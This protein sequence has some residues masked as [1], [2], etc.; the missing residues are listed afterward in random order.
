M[1]VLIYMF[2]GLVIFL[3]FLYMAYK[4]IGFI[5]RKIFSKYKFSNTYIKFISF[6]II[7]IP[8]I[9]IQFLISDYMNLLY[10]TGNIETKEDGTLKGNANTGNEEKKDTKNE[11]NTHDIDIN[12][13]VMLAGII[14]DEDI[15]ITED[16]IDNTQ[17]VISEFNFEK[18]IYISENSRDIFLNIL[19]DATGLTYSINEQG[20]LNEVSNEKQNN[21][22]EKINKMI[23]S[24]FTTIIDVNEVYKATINN[25]V[26]DFIVEETMYVKNSKYNDNIRISIIN[27]N[28]LYNNEE[29][30][31]KDIAEEILLKILEG[32]ETI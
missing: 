9:I 1:E 17:K 4:F 2:I 16:N 32:I 28:M 30:S 6:I 7:V 15:L 31:K 27:P 21:L 18:G 24:N 11:V 8:Y 13:R 14:S 3:I 23:K 20:Y 12:S 26:F 5:L 10:S 22:A 29:L 25:T 19:M